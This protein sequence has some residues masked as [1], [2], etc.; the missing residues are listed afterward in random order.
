[1]DVS[2]ESLSDRRFIRIGVRATPGEVLSCRAKAKFL[3]RWA[4]RKLDEDALM[5]TILVKS[6]C[7][8]REEKSIRV[9]RDSVEWIGASEE[10]S[11]ASMPRSRSSPKRSAY[12]WSKEIAEL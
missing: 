5:T 3:R 10:A 6:L 12:W 2:T 8:P 11:D 4:L 9:K 1:V 7:S